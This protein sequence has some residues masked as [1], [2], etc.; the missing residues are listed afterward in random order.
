MMIEK[1]SKS[2]LPQ[3]H[4]YW[5]VLFSA[6]FV[7]M[8]ARARLRP[9][10]NFTRA[11]Q[12]SAEYLFNWWTICAIESKNHSNIFWAFFSLSLC[13]RAHTTRTSTSISTWCF[14]INFN[15]E[16]SLT[17]LLNHKHIQQVLRKINDEKQRYSSDDGG[18]CDDDVFKETQDTRLISLA[19]QIEA[20]I[21]VIIA[22]MRCMPVFFSFSFFGDQFAGQSNRARLRKRSKRVILPLIKFKCLLAISIWRSA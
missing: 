4:T 14:S 21:I 10:E 15:F 3:N 5:Y 1:E 7:C 22:S 17:P 9:E 12:S 18:D 19:R 8:C 20:I 11:K 2:S 6:A 13:A 16:N